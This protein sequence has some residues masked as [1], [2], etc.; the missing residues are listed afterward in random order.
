MK[1]KS[2]GNDDVMPASSSA[3]N[4]VISGMVWKFDENA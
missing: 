1:W 2:V 3:P 4:S